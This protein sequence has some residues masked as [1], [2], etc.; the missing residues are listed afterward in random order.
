M[1]FCGQSSTVFTSMIARAVKSLDF[2]KKCHNDE[3][4]GILLIHMIMFRYFEL[5]L[6]IFVVHFSCLLQSKLP[7][8]PT[9]LQCG[10]T[11]TSG[12]FMIDFVRRVLLL[13][14][15]VLSMQK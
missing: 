11:K 4:I 3:V 12:Q 10:F 15:P 14:I 1:I 5:N 6:D 7:I 9:P 13:S 2:S 8:V